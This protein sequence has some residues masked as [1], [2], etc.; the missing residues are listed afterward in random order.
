M[1]EDGVFMSSLASDISAGKR[2]ISFML[3]AIAEE[4]LE[5]SLVLL[6]RLFYTDAEIEVG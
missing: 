5:L 3:K 1:L 6:A 2:K 4:F